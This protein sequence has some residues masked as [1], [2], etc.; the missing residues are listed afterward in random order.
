MQKFQENKTITIYDIAKEAGVSPSTVSRVLTNSANVR[1]EKKEK[2]LQLIEKYNFKP[3]ALAKGLSDTKSKVIGIIIADVR[4]PFYATIFVACEMAAKRRGYMTLLCN[5]LG[6]MQQELEQ[7]EILK[8]QRVDAI[9]HLGGSA[10]DLETNKE[11]V[12]KVNELLN[13]PLI[14]T[15]KLDGVECYKVQIDAKKAAELLLDHLVEQG[16]RKIALIGGRMD[17]ISTYEKY[18]TY[19]KMVEKYQLEYR[20][21]YIVKGGY[22][23]ETGY[24]GM[25]QLIENNIIPTA[26]V[27]IND[28][29]AA[30]V[31]RCLTEQGYR[32]PE[33]V[34]VVSYDNTDITELLIPKLTSIDYNYDLFGEKLIDTAIGV[35]EKEEI[36][37]FQV[38]TPNLVVRESSNRILE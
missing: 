10:D 22:D 25:K 7:I 17:V 12:Q 26:V 1:S 28:F 31:M 34:A 38:I 24:F 14:I 35:I 32:I 9:I 5:S 6:D 36:P 30:G 2:I 11:Y 20:D 37:E 4:N 33:D 8:Q 16:H 18:Q 15:G 27:A 23:N 19:L 3:N 21:E 29:T 13:I